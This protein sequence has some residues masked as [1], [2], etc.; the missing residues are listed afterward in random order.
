[1]NDRPPSSLD[2]RPKFY[3]GTVGG[4]RFATT[5]DDRHETTRMSWQTIVGHDDVVAQFRRR[6][7]SGRITGTF[8]FV[9]PA[10]IGK[11]T[12]AQKLAQALFCRGGT[13]DSLDPCGECEDCRWSE[14]G[15]HPDLSIVAKPSDKSEIPLQLL[16]GPPEHRLREGLC[17]EI[18]LKPSHGGRR[19]AIIDDADY[20]NEEGANCLLK[21]L[22]EPP[23]KSL[24]I[25]IGTSPDRQL[26]TI[27][28][29][30]QIVRFRP[31][32][33]DDTARLILELGYA[34]DPAAARRLAAMSNGS[35]ERARRLAD[36]ALA[37]FRTAVLTK[38]ATD[39]W[40]AISAAQSLNAFLDDAGKD[41]GVRRERFRQA[42]GFLIDFYR[43][44]ATVRAGGPSTDDLELQQA[45]ERAATHL[46]CDLETLA[47][48]VDRLLIG[49]EQIDRN[50]H[51]ATLVDALCDDVGRIFVGKAFAA[52]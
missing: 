25:L 8:L 35:L 37:E 40:R 34:A 45:A 10:G 44:T 49:L 21:T 36:P 32:S 52:T 24:M 39:G 20:L 22:E 19:T 38:L 5:A 15:T 17:Y 6:L 28:S 46:A 43:T 14:A 9:G 48:V 41:A 18:G 23:P 51:A 13:N 31:P 29:R 26:S 42:L 27:R 33:L 4:S 1:M 30:S 7:R 11:R 47:G 2:R 16:I 12:F 3:D 50:A